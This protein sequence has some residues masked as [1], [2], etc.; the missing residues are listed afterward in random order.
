MST[1][2]SAGLKKYV[3]LIGTDYLS[4]LYSQD[5]VKDLIAEACSQY[6]LSDL[7]DLR[8]VNDVLTDSI[9]GFVDK[10][11]QVMEMCI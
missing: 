6:N 11:K 3:Y 10:Y 8:I 2:C 7:E 1:N 9:T 5:Q 4:G